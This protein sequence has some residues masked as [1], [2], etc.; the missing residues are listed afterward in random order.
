MKTNKKIV[1]TTLLAVTALVF[2]FV[3][4]RGHDWA[5]DHVDH[6]TATT[7]F[8]LTCTNCHVG[9]QVD[10]LFTQFLTD[11]YLSPF[12]VA[13]SPD[14]NYLYVVGQ[15][16]NSF[17]IVDLNEKV[18]IKKIEVGNHPHS[19]TLNEDG[20]SAYVSNQWDDNVIEILLPEGNIVDTLQTGAG[21]AELQYEGE[22]NMLYVVNTFTSDV[23]IIDLSSGQELKRL[24][25]G[26][27]PTGAS[28]TPDG[29][30]LMVLS[31]R[32]KHIEFRTPPKVEA[33]FI[34][35]SE[36]RLADRKE[37]MS[38]HIMENIDYTPE[39]EL[40]LFTLIRPKNLVP[41]VQIENGWMI[42]HG[43]GVYNT[44]TGKMYQLLLDE[45]NKFYAD[46]FD[47]KVSPDG[48]Y[49]VV[50][51]SGANIL[52]IIEM[53]K[54]KSLLLRIDAG[55][56]RMPENNLGLSK[57]FVIKRIET[58]SAPKGMAFSPDGSKLYYA[59]YLNDKIGIVDMTSFS[60]GESIVLSKADQNTPIRQGQRLFYNAGGT[61]QYQYSC[62]TCHPDGHEDGLTYDMALKPGIDLTNVQTLRELPKTSPFK[63]NGHN[64]SVY[65]Q[66]GMR[67]SKFV[68]RTESYS[69][70][71]LT[72]LTSYILT[73]LKHPPN[74]FRLPNGELTEAQERGK[75][76]FYR[77]MT[78]DGREIPVG[79]QCVTCHPPPNFTNR[80]NADVG[81]KKEHDSPGMTFDSPN[82][83]NIYES[84]PYLHDG[85]AQ[86]LEEIWTIY[87]DNDE[88]GAAN[89]MT[90]NQLN[91]LIEYLKS[92]GSAKYY[93]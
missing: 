77:T 42:N 48:K 57:E 21:P 45:P 87:N 47:V 60:N 61:F 85:S 75:E 81:T 17:S 73:Q 5:R 91:D 33:T 31:R 36:Q 69:P 38:A 89:D 20:T 79:N 37:L 88:H 54:L 50:S 90:K 58:G 43:I 2:V 86:T 63:W 62:Y 11:D 24:S 32:T 74:R 51:H 27:N 18:V 65:M 15:E 23:S 46:P 66:D 6:M 28:L 55:E 14:G 56:I 82:L 12:N 70:E 41:A 22:G 29:E 40:A 10:N 59:E 72:N 25:V 78:N 53:S 71:D 1:L 19:V 9:R 35:T 67:F 26:N 16:D 68:T 84:A 3:A 83:N 7:G 92:L 34:S 30:T 52:S 49:A 80:T 64:V 13:I 76:I 4:K 93:K 44:S 8:P 39:G